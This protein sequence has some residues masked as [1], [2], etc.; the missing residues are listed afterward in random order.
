MAG[1]LAVWALVVAVI[2]IR[3]RRV[4]NLLLILAAVPACASLLLAR[5]GLLNVGPVLA[6]IGALIGAALL[7]PG[8][9]LR[10]VGAGDVKLAALL[11]LMVGAVGVLWT[12]L[13]AALALGG[14][15]IFAKLRRPKGYRLP[16]AVALAAG[17]ECWLAHLVFLPGVE[18]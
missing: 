8:Y 4:P 17:F 13:G 9:L 7:L 14:M 1:I 3:Q 16:A 11:G 10:Q 6:L 2:D 12:L 5:G 18:T 15:A